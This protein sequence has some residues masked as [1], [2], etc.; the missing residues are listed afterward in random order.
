MFHH[1]NDAHFENVTNTV[2]AGHKCKYV[3]ENWGGNFQ[4]ATNL[5]H[6]FSP[7]DLKKFNRNLC[8]PVTTPQPTVYP[9]IYAHAI[10]F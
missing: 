7:W 2:A 5:V 10:T 3:A 1:D 6:Y 8:I 4:K 9:T